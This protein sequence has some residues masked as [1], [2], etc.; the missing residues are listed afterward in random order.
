M[1]KVEKP[2]AL[3]R[4]RAGSALL[5][6][7]PNTSTATGGATQARCRTERFRITARVLPDGMS[8]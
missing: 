3:E 8:L 5:E 6:D 2:G 7:K 1:Q 4:D